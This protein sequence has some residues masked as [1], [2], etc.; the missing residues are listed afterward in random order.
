MEVREME[1]VKTLLAHVR[2]QLDEAG[3]EQIPMPD[4]EARELTAT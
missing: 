3:A 4:L 1:D 2:H